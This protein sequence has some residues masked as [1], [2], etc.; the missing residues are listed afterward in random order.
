MVNEHQ[1][2]GS[3]EEESTREISP[4]K[5][6]DK[7]REDEPH[8][9]N[10]RQVPLV[11][12]DNDLVLAQVTNIGD[13]RFPPRLNNHPSNVRPKETL[14]GRVGIEIGV[15]VAMVSSVASGPPFDRSFDGTGSTECEKVLEGEGSGVGTVSPQ[16]VVASGDT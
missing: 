7:S 6:S 15:G 5:S 14:V 16:P 8:S 2:S 13:S 10:K 9:D 4:S 12:P 11:L 1:P 3:S